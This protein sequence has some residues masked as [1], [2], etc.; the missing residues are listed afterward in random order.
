MF[1]LVMF[2]LCLTLGVHVWTWDKLQ[3]NPFGPQT[4]TDIKEAE[5]KALIFALKSN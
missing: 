3:L 2:L 4:E 5:N 1:H